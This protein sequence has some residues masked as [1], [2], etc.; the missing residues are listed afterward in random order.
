MECLI[1]GPEGSGKSLLLKRLEEHSKVKKKAPQTAGHGQPSFSK[2]D[3]AEL[4]SRD[5]NQSLPTVGVNFTHLKLLKGVTCSLRES[6]GQMVPLWPNLYKDCKM[7]IFVIDSSNKVQ[8]SASTILLLDVVSSPLLQ[9]KPILV[10]F[11]KTDS[12]LG[13]GLVE[14]KSVIRMD[15]I[16]SHAT[17]NVTVVDGS[18][19]TGEGIAAIHDWLVRNCTES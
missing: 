3:F 16:V 18:C 13:L 5:T 9:N 12:P 7:V 4:A 11:N 14:Y 8:V 2:A 1:L 6:G 19:W 15:D 10:F 17:Q